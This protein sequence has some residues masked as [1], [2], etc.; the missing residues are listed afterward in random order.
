MF[1]A[2]LVHRC[3][4]SRKKVYVTSDGERRYQKLFHSRER[5]RQF[6]DCSRDSHEGRE[7]KELVGFCKKGPYEIHAVQDERNGWCLNGP[8]WVSKWRVPLS[9]ME[10]SLRR[11]GNNLVGS[12]LLCR[13]EWPLPLSS[14]EGCS[15]LKVTEQTEDKNCSCDIVSFVLIPLIPV[16]D[17]SL[18]LSITLEIPSAQNVMADITD[19]M[20]SNIVSVMVEEH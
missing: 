10:G 2:I 11:W 6:A 18:R 5:S 1:K 4:N 13:W 9:C 8:W 19:T 17:D 20:S 3:L 14:P 16:E 7:G 12:C 15:L